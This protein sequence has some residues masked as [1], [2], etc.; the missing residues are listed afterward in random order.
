MQV[1]A[2]N[3]ELHQRSSASLGLG[4]VMVWISD[5]PFSSCQ[6]WWLLLV[7]CISVFTW[8]FLSQ[9]QC[10]ED[11][12]ERVG[13]RAAFAIK[14]QGT[15]AKLGGRSHCSWGFHCTAW[16]EPNSRLPW[17]LQNGKHQLSCLGSGTE[18][19]WEEAESRCGLLW[20]PG[21]CCVLAEGCL[22][23]GVQALWYKVF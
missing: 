23:G 10:S 20:E 19:F 4:Q 17:M 8:L 15:D 9:R 1:S 21:F 13:A 7:V 16:A 11:A 18:G 22:T 14:C 6:P 3:K 2:L 12:W 5:G